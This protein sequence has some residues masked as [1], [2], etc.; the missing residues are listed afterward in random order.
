MITRPRLQEFR[1]R[2]SASGDIGEVLAGHQEVGG[3]GGGVHA[4]VVVCKRTTMTLDMG[5]EAT[6]RKHRV[7]RKKEAEAGGCMGDT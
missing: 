5:A 7:V 1:L 2:F 4:R 6:A 3:G